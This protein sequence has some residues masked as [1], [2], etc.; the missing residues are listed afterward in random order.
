MTRPPITPPARVPRA[1]AGGAGDARPDTALGDLRLSRREGSVQINLRLLLPVHRHYRA[2]LRDCDA[3]GLE[4]S[5]TELIH[6]LLVL[7]GPRDIAGVRQLV[8]AY[9]AAFD[10]V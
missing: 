1:F 3:D 7:R 10:E 9:R 8:R 6:A 5:M 4:S 2:L